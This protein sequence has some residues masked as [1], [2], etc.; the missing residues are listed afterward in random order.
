MKKIS[1][2]KGKG[3]NSPARNTN[4]A[5]ASAKPNHQTP[6]TAAKIEP[7]HSDLDLWADG[8]AEQNEEA[9]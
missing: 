8:E 3:L 1:N 4:K 2:T 9:I 6:I 5:V 7:F